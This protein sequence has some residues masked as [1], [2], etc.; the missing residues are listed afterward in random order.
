MITTNIIK[1]K[2]EHFYKDK[3]KIHVTKKNKEINNGTI[4][5]ISDTTF[6]LNDDRKG[7]TLLFFSEIYDI[8]LYRKERVI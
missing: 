8:E 2:A 3:S 4:I 6:K 5:S 1:E 7:I